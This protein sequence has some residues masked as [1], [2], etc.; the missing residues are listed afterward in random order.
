[1][2]GDLSAYNSSNIKSLESSRVGLLKLQ[3]V[4]YPFMNTHLGPI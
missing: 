1:M 2:F 4:S 3:R